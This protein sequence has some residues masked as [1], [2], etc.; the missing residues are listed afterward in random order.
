MR[1]KP[2]GNRLYALI[3]MVHEPYFLT[4]T[5]VSPLVPPLLMQPLL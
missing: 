1:N 2:W 5:E 4:P 3:L